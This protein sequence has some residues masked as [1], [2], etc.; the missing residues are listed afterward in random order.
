[1]EYA[2]GYH[3]DSGKKMNV[4]HCYPSHI[5]WIDYSEDSSNNNCMA[6]K[7]GLKIME[8][9][10]TQIQEWITSKIENKLKWIY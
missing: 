7:E 1:M 6:C 2:K 8:V 9:I 5:K 4:H 10:K 3:F